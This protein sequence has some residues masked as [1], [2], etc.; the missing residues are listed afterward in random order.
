MNGRLVK[1]IKKYTKYNYLEYLDAIKHWPFRNR[2]RLAWYIAFGK[3]R[4]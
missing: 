4:G 3:R 2:L 1:K